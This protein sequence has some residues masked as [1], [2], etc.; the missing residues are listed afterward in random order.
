M[1]ADRIDRR[2]QLGIGGAILV[3]C[4]LVLA[5]AQTSYLVAVGAVLWGLQLGIIDGLLGASVADA[6]PQD[7]RGTAFG[8]Y[9]S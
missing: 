8:V 1:L 4:H 7:L 5:G 9:Y 3:A 2:L 6:A